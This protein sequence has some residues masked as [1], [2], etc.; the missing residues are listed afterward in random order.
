MNQVLGRSIEQ[1]AVP[2]SQPGRHDL[3]R[4]NS[5]KYG[6][7][8]LLARMQVSDTSSIV[9][10]AR[11]SFPGLTTNGVIERIL[12][13]NPDCVWTVTPKATSQN[14]GVTGFVAMLPLTSE[15]LALLSTGKFDSANPRLSYVCRNTDKPAGIYVWAAYLPGLLSGG[16]SLFI[17]ELSKPPYANVTLYSRPTTEAGVR[18][19]HALGFQQGATI[20]GTFA[21]H[22]FEYN[23]SEHDPAGAYRPAV[24]PK[25]DVK[26]A[27]SMEDLVRVISVRSAVY[28]GE[29]ACPYE[30]EFDGNDMAST[31]LLG[32]VGDEPVGCI[33]IRC[34]SEFAKI[35]RLAVRKEYRNSRMAFKLV[36]GAIDLCSMKGYQRLYGHAQKRLVSFWS[37]FGFHQ[38]PGGKELVFSDFD[39]VEM[40]AEIQPHSEAIRIGTDPYKIIRP[41]GHWHLPGRLEISAKRGVTRPSI[42]S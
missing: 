28:I 26:V 27:S 4:L 38:I 1:N 25:M 13:H 23:R 35:E 24:A 8:L 37:R 34:F 20:N 41:E 11:P 29:Q 16:F 2:L 19:N 17:D 21:A 31:H 30:E 12:Q 6:R 39:Y 22:L 3:S 18:F 42:D 7:R 15:G 40:T 33:R 32:Y 36:R 10:A 5:A 14:A 9:D